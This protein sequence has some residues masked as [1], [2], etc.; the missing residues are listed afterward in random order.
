MEE[1]LKNFE[2]LKEIGI[3]EIRIAI[4]D[5]GLYRVDLYDMDQYF[6]NWFRHIKEYGRDPAEAMKKAVKKW[7]EKYSH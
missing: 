2:K 7:K 5:D 3:T 4:C 6:Q 1:K